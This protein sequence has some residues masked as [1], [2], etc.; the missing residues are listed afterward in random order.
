MTKPKAKARKATATKPSEAP[1]LEEATAT[2]PPGTDVGQDEVAA[3]LEA[4]QD[5]GYR[6]T[7]YD[8]GDY[9]VAGVTGKNPPGAPV[10][11]AGR[12][13]Q[14]VVGQEGGRSHADAR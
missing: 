7:T 9:T 8:D 10:D 13:V 4:E 12:L 2:T 14:P 1:T 6:G 5:A 11:A 3:R